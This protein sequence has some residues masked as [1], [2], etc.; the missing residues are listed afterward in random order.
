MESIS[1]VARATGV[2]RRAITEGMKE[3]K[4][5]RTSKVRF[6]E[7]RRSGA[8]VRDERERWT[9]IPVCWRIW[10]DWWIR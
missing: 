1:V 5:P 4:K 9:R 3:L 7:A 6:E 2:S 8:E 10:I